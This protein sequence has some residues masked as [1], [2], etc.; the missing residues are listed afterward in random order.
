MKKKAVVVVG[1]TASGKTSLGI[2]IAKSFNGEIISADSMQ[3]YKEL[4]VSTAKP[5]AA[6][7]QGIKHHLIDFVPVSE[8]YSVSNF[9]KDA[10]ECLDKIISEGKLPVIVGGTGL[11]I[12]SFLSNTLFLEDA[13]S[14]TLRDQLRH[15]YE[16][17]GI[18]KLYEELS[19]ID[20]DAAR[21]IHPN[22]AVRVIRA[23]EV[24]RTT[25]M[26]ITRQKELSHKIESDIDP[27]FIGI[28]YSDRDKLYERIN[29][30]VDLMAQNGLL[31]EAEVFFKLNPS[32]TAMNAIGCKELKPYFEGTDTIENCLDNLK[33]ETR[34]Y[35]K[36]QLTWFK[37]NQNIN[38]F[39]A[40]KISEEE[41]FDRVFNLITEFTKG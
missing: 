35:A 29:L 8:T 11:Y 31:E 23:L 28:N 1:A 24:Y 22:N 3:I 27:L 39:Y 16:T 20:P 21:S 10:G 26:T 7:M 4:S 40:D 5:D 30:R 25:G 38:W 36:R 13:V 12:D 17:H 32:K 33:R 18:A 41:L 15:E 6:E 37:R 34:R 2:K 14:Q 9:C 19:S